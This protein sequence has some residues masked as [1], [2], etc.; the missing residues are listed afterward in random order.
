MSFKIR[1]KSLGPFFCVVIFSAVKKG[2]INLYSLKGAS[3][4]VFGLV[5]RQIRNCG[6]TLADQKVFCWCSKFRIGSL[7]C[8]CSRADQHDAGRRH[9][10]WYNDIQKSRWLVVWTKVQRNTFRTQYYSLGIFLFLVFLQT[11]ASQ[12]RRCQVHA[13]GV[14]SK[15]FTWQSCWLICWAKKWT[16][17]SLGSFVTVLSD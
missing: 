4:Y 13:S 12:F 16:D 9:G 8:P 10:G 3:E 14:I 5:Q 6:E 17:L 7:A 15:S 11:L 1:I 2:I